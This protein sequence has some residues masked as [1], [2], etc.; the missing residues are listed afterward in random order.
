[1]T[2]KFI[3]YNLITKVIGIGVTLGG[4]LSRQIPIYYIRFV[5]C[6]KDRERQQT[7]FLSFF[8]VRT[9]GD[10]LLPCEDVE[11]KKIRG[12]A[13]SYQTTNPPV[14]FLGILSSRDM[15]PNIVPFLGYRV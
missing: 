7:S 10:S 3:F 12:E 13:G 15:R 5:P 11:I 9:K 1:V 2:W 4:N 6:I 14:F 8:N